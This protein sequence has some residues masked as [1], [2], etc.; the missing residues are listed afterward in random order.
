MSAIIARFKRCNA[1]TWL[2]RSLAWDELFFGLILTTAA[3]GLAWLGS[4]LP[5]AGQWTLAIIV[6][7]L[8]ALLLG[9]GGVRCFGPL[10]LYDLIRVARRRQHVWLRCL[11]GGLLLAG[12]AFAYITFV[13]EEHGSWLGV[14]SGFTLPKE[15]LRE[16]MPVLANRV[17]ESFLILQFLAIYLLTP[18]YVAPAIA[19]EKERRGLDYLFATDLRNREIVLSLF[20]SRTANLLLVLLTGLPIFSLLPLLGGVEPGAVLAGFAASAATLISLAGWSV[21]CSVQARRARTAVLFAYLGP[22]VYLLLSAGLW[23]WLVEPRYEVTWIHQSIISLATDP[24]SQPAP[25]PAESRLPT[26]STLETRTQQFGLGNPWV[27]WHFV[28]YHQR[29]GAGEFNQLLANALR[30]YTLIH[31]LIALVCLTW[32]VLRLRAVALHQTGRPDRPRPKPRELFWT[33]IRIRR[34]AVVRWPLLWKEVRFGGRPFRWFS[35]GALYVFFVYLGCLPFLLVA[36]L[37]Y[38]EWFAARSVI[39]DWL[40]T[41]GRESG[42]ALAY[43]MLL[44]V[45][46][47]AAGSVSGER[48]RGSLDALVLAIE[49]LNSVLFAKLLGSLW[50]VRRLGLLLLVAWCVGCL[51]GA[52]G[53]G[54]ALVLAVGLWL[55]YAVFIACVGLWFSVVCPTSQRALLWTVV[56]V[57]TA[58]VAHWIVWMGFYVVSNLVQD[59]PDA[60]LAQLCN[61]FDLTPPLALRAFTSH[62]NNP[63]LAHGNHRELSLLAL[64]ALLFLWGA[65]LFWTLACHRFRLQLGRWTPRPQ[66]P[67]R[68]SPLEFTWNPES[69]GVPESASLTGPT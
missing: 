57:A 4:Q 24:D 35:R 46:I 48:E 55:V 15:V 14:F 62:T 10:L 37:A 30:P 67:V 44:G 20:V 12:F 21:L 33:G 45:A 3:L 61:S 50:S 27:V 8:L 23:Q 56:T 9:R 59:A 2:A 52:V 43:L 6:T 38:P 42:P 65:V 28:D 54:L 19:E 34:P 31:S 68:S 7:V 32:S 60:E 22:L 29:L 26:L 47:R 39:P 53:N 58:F 18:A 1:W 17:F 64:Q 41:A 36:Y 49:N 63:A 40:E 25:L 69:G 5:A 11:Y 16:K 13:L 66:Q 51:L